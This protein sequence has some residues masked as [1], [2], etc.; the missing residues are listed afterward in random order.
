MQ[1]SQQ[2]NKQQQKCYHLEAEAEGFQYKINSKESIWNLLY[3]LLLVTSFLNFLM[4]GS[5][6][7]F[8]TTL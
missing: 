6:S 2:A 1:T 5:R 4:V 7:K 8:N 3:F